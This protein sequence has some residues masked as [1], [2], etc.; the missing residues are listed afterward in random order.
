MSNE[1]SR[2]QYELD[3]ISFLSP[4]TFCAARLAEANTCV[5]AIL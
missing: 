5:A 3:T 1:I 4:V 2:T